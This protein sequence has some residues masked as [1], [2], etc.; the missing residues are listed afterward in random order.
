MKK[1]HATCIVACETLKQ[2]LLAAM[3]KRGC[4]YPVAWIDAGKHTWPDKL[5]VSVQEAIDNIPPSYETV[6]L[7]FGFCGNAM[8]GIEARNHRLVMPRAA[9]CIPLFIGSREERETYGT[10]TYFFTE[11]YLNSGGSAVTDASR[12]FERY[13]EEDGLYI[14]K[15]MLGHYQDFA[16]VDT[17]V[18]DVGAVKS[19]V[20]DFA[21]QLEIPV[22]LIPGSLRLIDALLSGAW[23]EDEFLVLE[24]GGK[25]SFE[26]SLG[27]GKGQDFAGT[28]A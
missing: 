17:G 27:A 24:P 12:I 13:G 3:E 11:G 4:D 2:E 9:D 23:R 18:F 5:R 25:V 16:V 26:D 6:L 21:G 1:E 10:R 22:K 7:L 15:E 14:L 19:R 8:V 28:P 20:E